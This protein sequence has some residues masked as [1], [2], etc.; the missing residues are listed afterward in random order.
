[1]WMR[2]L[3]YD[4][5]NTAPFRHENKV[6]ENKSIVILSGNKVYVKQ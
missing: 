5:K 2:V 3:K 1:M 4:V 6:N